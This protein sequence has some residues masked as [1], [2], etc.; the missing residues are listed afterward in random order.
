[1]LTCNAFKLSIA[2]ELLLN[3]KAALTLSAI[4]FPLINNSVSICFLMFYKPTT[5]IASIETDAQ[6][7]LTVSIIANSLFL[8]LKLS[9]KLFFAVFII[10]LFQEVLH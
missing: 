3:S 2:D 8:T 10:Y 6:A 4:S 7:K 1:M 5:E 9:K